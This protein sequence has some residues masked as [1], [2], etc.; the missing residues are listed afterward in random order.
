MN[1]A[2]FACVTLMSDGRSFA[3]TQPLGESIRYATCE[4]A[5]DPDATL[6]ILRYRFDGN[7]SSSGEVDGTATL[8]WSDA[9]DTPVCTAY[10]KVDQEVDGELPEADPGLDTVFAVRHIMDG[11]LTDPGCTTLDIDVMALQVEELDHAWFW[12]GFSERWTAWDGSTH[13][14]VVFR[15][16]KTNAYVDGE[17]YPWVQAE[18][19]AG[20][21][22]SFEILFG[23]A[24]DVDGNGELPVTG[25]EVWQWADG[26][27]TCDESY[28]VVG[29]WEIQAQTSRALYEV[30]LAR[31]AGSTG[32]TSGI[33]RTTRGL[34]TNSITTTN[35]VG[36]EDELVSATLTDA[37]TNDDVPRTRAEWSATLDYAETEGVLY[38]EGIAP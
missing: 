26:E 1:E 29:A 19:G 22:L 9:S 35:D 2:C 31:G 7:V 30:L 3:I 5:L 38:F 28:F 20:D 37:T 34:G 8:T 17:W 11:G 27:Q 14:R 18:P 4:G 24:A 33:W 12:L 15:K 16:D 36:T 25:S 10:F 6:T 13:D 21:A 23:T 32:C